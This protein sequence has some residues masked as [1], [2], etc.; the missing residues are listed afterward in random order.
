MQRR[1]SEERKAEMILMC[2]ILTE[3]TTE[4][5]LRK[6]MGQISQKM[7]FRITRKRLFLN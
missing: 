1:L 4:K 5:N 2:F 6:G 3:A 7:T